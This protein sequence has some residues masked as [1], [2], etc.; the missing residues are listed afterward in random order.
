MGYKPLRNEDSLSEL[1]ST[2]ND[3]NMVAKRLMANRENANSFMLWLHKCVEVDRRGAWIF[4]NNNHKEFSA[5]QWEL[6]L[7]ALPGLVKKRSS[8]DEYLK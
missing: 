3:F 4:L 7:S 1:F 8:I 6:C 2:I 5:A